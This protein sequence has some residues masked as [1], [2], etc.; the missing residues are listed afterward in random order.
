[1]I[2]IMKT[3]KWLVIIAVAAGCAGGFIVT[4]LHAADTESSPRFFRGKL[5]ERIQE[6]LDLTDDQMGQIKTVLKSEKDSLVHLATDVH[7]ARTGLRDAIQAPNATEASVRAASARVAGAESNLAVERLKLYSQISPLLT[8][9]QHEKLG[10]FESK[11]D[12]MVDAG[13]ERI[14]E[15][16]AE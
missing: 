9:E 7:E 12:E 13:I 14:G 15:R 11:M 10:E 1:M 4:K 8:A 2:G 3:S 6:K 16:L 5:W